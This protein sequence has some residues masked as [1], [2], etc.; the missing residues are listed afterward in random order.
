MSPN[1][2]VLNINVL[3]INREV[4]EV[5]STL[6][7]PKALQITGSMYINEKNLEGPLHS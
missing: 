2:S 6:A 5:Q 1:F 3:Y 4:V 7:L